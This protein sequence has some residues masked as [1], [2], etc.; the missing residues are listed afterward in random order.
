MA[1]TCNPSY[2]GDRGRKIVHSRYAWALEL[3]IDQP[4]QVSEA[5]SQS[6][7]KKRVRYIVWWWGN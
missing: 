7:H 4:E 3:V 2:S 5:L 1:Q 6:K